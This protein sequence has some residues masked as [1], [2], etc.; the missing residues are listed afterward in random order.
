MKT[1]EII[2]SMLSPLGL[3]VNLI[4]Y[5]YKRLLFQNAQKFSILQIPPSSTSHEIRRN[6]LQRKNKP[7]LAVCPQINCWRELKVV[8]SWLGSQEEIWHSWWPLYYS[9]QNKQ[10][11]VTDE[12]ERQQ[13]LQSHYGSSCIVEHCIVKHCPIITNKL[14]KNSHIQ[15]CFA[16]LSLVKFSPLYAGSYFFDSQNQN[17][18]QQL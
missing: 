13:D 12:L 18:T 4:K 8:E 11:H 2:I 6:N 1:L 14:S 5:T 17:V 15:P 9:K 10:T 3:P 7:P 16:L